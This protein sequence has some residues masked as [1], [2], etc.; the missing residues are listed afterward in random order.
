M[1]CWFNPSRTIRAKGPVPSAPPYQ[2]SIPALLAATIAL[3][4]PPGLIEKPSTIASSPGA[5][6]ATTL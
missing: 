3:N 6:T 5:G 4:P 2:T 1:A